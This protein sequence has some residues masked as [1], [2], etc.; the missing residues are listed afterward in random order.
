MLRLELFR[1]ERKVTNAG[2]ETRVNRPDDRYLHQARDKI[3][4]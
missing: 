1:P 3:A 2:G 4:I